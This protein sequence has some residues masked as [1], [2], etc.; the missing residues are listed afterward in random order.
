M[1]EQGRAPSSSVSSCMN[2]FVCSIVSAGRCPFV[3]T[4]SISPPHACTQRVHDALHTQKL[5]ILAHAMASCRSTASPGQCLG[6]TRAALWPGAGRQVLQHGAVLHA[7]RWAS[8]GLAP[9]AVTLAT[10]LLDPH[11]RCRSGCESACLSR[12]PSVSAVLAG[13]T[14]HASSWLLPAR[15]LQ[16][17]DTHSSIRPAVSGSAAEPGKL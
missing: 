2:C 12:C 7:D 13:A 4:A 1:L 3:C 10:H 11:P 14:L 6:P 5:A 8:C 17:P 16:R 15:L 9:P